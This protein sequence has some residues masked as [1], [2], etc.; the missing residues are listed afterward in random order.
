ML[1]A[2]LGTPENAPQ[3]K[4]RLTEP[5][6]DEFQTITDSEWPPAFPQGCPRAT[7]RRRKQHR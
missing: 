2:L 7:P 5:D 1:H 4:Q 3:K 6:E